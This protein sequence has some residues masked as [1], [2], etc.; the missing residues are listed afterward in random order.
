MDVLHFTIANY[1][2][3]NYCLCITET[4]PSSVHLPSKMFDVGLY[5]NEH[6]YTHKYT[7]VCA[8]QGAQ[9]SFHKICCCHGIALHLLTLPWKH[10]NDDWHGA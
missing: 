6:T 7:Q 9:N 8:Q 2:R 5:Y 10:K 4:V 3:S 1:L